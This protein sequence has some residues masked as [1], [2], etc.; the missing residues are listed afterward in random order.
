MSVRYR[1]LDLQSPREAINSGCVRSFS[2]SLSCSNGLEER[3]R[4]LIF[5]FD[6]TLWPPHPSVG[7]RD[8]RISPSLLR[9][10]ASFLFS[11]EVSWSW[12]KKWH[13]ARTCYRSPDITI[14][15]DRELGEG[16]LI[17]MHP[18]TWKSIPLV[19]P[20]WRKLTVLTYFL[21]SR[22]YGKQ[23]IIRYTH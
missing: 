5:R 3:F 10:C 17:F 8:S 1:Y 21:T 15:T 2:W 23:L 9:N 6:F 14:P 7:S 13:G 16:W 18:W 12:Q 4:F 20:L 19:R 11:L 22:S